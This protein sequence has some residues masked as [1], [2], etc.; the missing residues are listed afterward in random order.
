MTVQPFKAVHNVI[1]KAWFSMNQ[2]KN[3][4][5]DAETTLPFVYAQGKLAQDDIFSMTANHIV[6]SGGP[7]LDEGLYRDVAF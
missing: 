6:T 4:Y 2:S 3:L 1:Q 7:E 5:W